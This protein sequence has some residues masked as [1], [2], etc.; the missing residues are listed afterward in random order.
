M[1]NANDTLREFTGTSQW[2]RHRMTGYLFTDGIKAMADKYSCYWL[3]DLVMSHQLDPVVKAESFQ[4]WKLERLIDSRFEAFATDG[5]KRQIA[6][7][8]IAYSDFEADR[9]T[10]YF[11]DGI[12]LLP[13]EY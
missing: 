2:Y 5:N 10:M 1:K 9:V 8:E 12:L 3:I 13:S 11:C 6:R 7:Q 4:T